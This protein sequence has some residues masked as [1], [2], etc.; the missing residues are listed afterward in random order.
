MLDILKIIPR[1][2]KKS[3]AGWY[4]FNAPCCI[5]RGETRDKRHRGG[6]KIDG[7]NWVYHC[8]NCNF[9]C[10]F[11]L[12][13]II[14]KSTRDFLGWLGLSDEDIRKESLSS[15]R[16]KHLILGG[17]TIGDGIAIGE[18]K[19]DKYKLPLSARRITEHDTKYV[20]YL[21]GRHLSLSDYN[22]FI[23]PKAPGREAN[24]I[25]IPYMYKGNVVGWTSRYLDDKKPK[26]KNEHQQVGYVFGVDFQKLHWEHVIVSEGIMNAISIRCLAVMHNEFTNVQLALIQHLGKQVIVV[27]DQDKAGLVLAHEAIKN[28]FSVS[29]P[30]WGSDAEGNLITDI[31]E[32]VQTYGKGGTL[33]S[34]MNASE[35]STIKIT[36]ALNK[37]KKRQNI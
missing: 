34:I 32:A 8:F 11:V 20:E 28:G 3:P 19:F 9:K 6:I 13:Q 30:N 31:N 26:Y 24:R 29:V 18:I 23:T 14:G 10:K 2:A 22:F 15:L 27:P 17:Q 33:L 7:N 5:H 4:S 12:G 35:S 37:M 21:K 16:Q 36:V 1:T 25:I